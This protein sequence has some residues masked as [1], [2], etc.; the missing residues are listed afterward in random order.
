MTQRP[1]GE[2][3]E[4]FRDYLDA[5]GLHALAGAEAAGL[6]ASEWYAMS[7]ISLAGSLTPGELSART[8]LTTG[9]TTRLIDRLERA[10]RV[11]RV[12]DPGDRRRVVVEPAPDAPDVDIDAIVGPARRRV[13][14]VLERYTPEQR[15]VLFDYFR[16]AA[17]A[18]REATEEIR[19]ALRDRKRR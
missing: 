5:V 17:P 8:G 12:A 11:R 4:I 7:Q 2:R 3:H 10:G 6:Q 1:S 13:G 16:R 19:A 18:F 15:E 14:E 9:A